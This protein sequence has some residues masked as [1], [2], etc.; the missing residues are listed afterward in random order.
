MKE[1]E[2]NK[3]LIFNK[4][5]IKKLIAKSPFSLLYEGINIKNNEPVAMK[6]EKKTNEFNY[7]ES[8]AFILF[9]LK[10]FGIQKV[11]TYGKNI[12]Y[13]ILIEELLGLS[14]KDLWKV[15]MSKKELLKNICMI[16][17]Q[18]IDRL[19]YIHSKDIIHKDI[20]PNNFLIGRKD[21]KNIYL[22]D[23]G[24]S[25]KY[26]ST[27][28]GKH[29]Q[30][31]KA[32]IICGSLDYLSINGNKGF[33]LSRRDDLESL[34]YVIISLALNS[35]PWSKIIFTKE[36]KTK[37]IIETYRMK[38]SITA[39]KLCE[40]LP[41]EFAE[42]LNYTKKLDFEQEPNYEYLK[43]LLT[44]VLLKNQQINDY[45][46]FWI[47]NKKNKKKEQENKVERINTLRRKDSS[48]KRLYNNI[49][50]SLEK[51][52]VNEL[53]SPNNNND[54]FYLKKRN[55]HPYKSFTNFSQ[56]INENYQKIRIIKNNS[57]IN[58][59]TDKKKNSNKWNFN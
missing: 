51:I 48:Q 35:L 46:F 22:I 52:K 24:F 15:K 25:Q 3:K 30:L 54:V 23:F 6:F 26:R 29:I 4:Y 42:F 44:S 50:K 13:N 14:I 2:I 28:T 12:C 32:K 53:Q 34:A 33:T 45:L 57:Q 49:K 59:I 39:E 37:A 41:N 17:L 38:N 43:N 27:R 11:I 47:I 10:G 7:L 36:N 20:K 31:R 21:P 18:I 8:E 40:G 9:N 58:T 16:G 55:I 56:G 1:K 5:K 19:Q